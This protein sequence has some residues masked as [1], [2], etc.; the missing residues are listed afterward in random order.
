MSREINVLQSKKVIP[1]TE[2]LYRALSIGDIRSAYRP[3][4]AVKRGE[5]VED[6]TQRLLVEFGKY[7]FVRVHFKTQEYYVAFGVSGPIITRFGKFELVSAEVVGGKWGIQYVLAFPNLSMVCKQKNIFVRVD[8]GCN[9]GM[10]FGDVTCDCAEQLH[11]AQELCVSNGSGVIISVPQHDGRGWGE[12]KMA[13]QRLMNEFN[14]DTVTAS[15]LF[16]GC[17]DDIDQRTYCESVLILRALGFG[18]KH[19]FNLGTNN[20]QKIAAF[21]ELGFSVS[22]QSSVVAESISEI[23]K[24]NLVAK[25]QN[26]GHDFNNGLL[27]KKL[28][29]GGMNSN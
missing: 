21:V 22:E 8:S 19:N 17:E 12:Y 24:K 18:S 2:H 20:P 9:S 28:N 3:V 10:L 14:I 29:L 23:A 25:S 27:N 1:I 11:K 13:T 16:Y 15:R 4:G 6:F 26:W 5:G 7:Q